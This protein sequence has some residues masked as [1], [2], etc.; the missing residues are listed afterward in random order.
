VP[1]GFGL[2][3]KDRGFPAQ[4]ATAAQAGFSYMGSPIM[5]NSPES[6]VKILVEFC[7]RKTKSTGSLLAFEHF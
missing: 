7:F 6:C 5:A 1:F 2:V 4:G 3:L